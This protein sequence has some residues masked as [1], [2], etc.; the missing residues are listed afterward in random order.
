MTLIVNGEE[1]YKVLI[2]GDTFI[3]QKG[4]W[5][6]CT[7]GPSFTGIP[8][9]MH[10]DASTGVTS[11]TGQIYT[12]WYQDKTPFTSK[13][14]TLPEG[15]HFTEIDKKIFWGQASGLSEW[16]GN[17]NYPLVLSDRTISTAPIKWPFSAAINSVIMALSF[18]LVIPGSVESSHNWSTTTVAPD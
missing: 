8:I 12:T 6:P 18:S 13:I 7:V 11:F 3:D 10:Y 2:G 15:F 9:L 5:L 4:V 16:N 17:T 1:A 14:I